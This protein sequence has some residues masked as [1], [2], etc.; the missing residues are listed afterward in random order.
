MKL[1]NW[2]ALAG[3]LVL[4]ATT[5]PVTAGAQS[6]QPFARALQS[7]GRGAHIGVT[8]RD[9]DT[10]DVKDAKTGVVIEEVEPGGPGDKAGMKTGDGITEFDGE[11]VRSSLQFSR[12]VRETPDGRSVQA[13]LSRGGQRL[14]VAVVPDRSTLGDDFGM[15]LLDGPLAPFA[16]PA[17]PAPARSP[18]PPAVPSPPS[19]ELFGR[20]RDTGRLGITIED[21]DTQL[22][23][24]F[25]VKDGVLVKSVE[26]GSAA[27]KA[28]LKAGDVITAVN[29]RHVYDVSDVTRALDRLDDEGE[30][31][32]DVTRDRK[33]QTL[34]GKI[35]AT[36]RR[37]R[38][39]SRAI[40]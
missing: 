26:A 16:V 28:G 23:E 33:T 1:S 30:F 13:V 32:F 34:K 11:R 18:R 22:A 9:V 36:A 19:F 40:V 15:R 12:L 31:V 38:S 14:T 4:A 2:G 25:G 7:V 3:A 5:A 39:R 10:T 21:L 27:A 20:M 24:Y 17:P 37:V 35:E 8:V 6:R 29:T